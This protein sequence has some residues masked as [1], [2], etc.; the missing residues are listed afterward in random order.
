MSYA[1]FLD[2]L[3]SWWGLCSAVFFS[4]GVLRLTDESVKIMASSFFNGG[5]QLAV[6]LMQQ[7]VDFQFGAAFLF[8]SF[9]VQLVT[10]L[11]PNLQFNSPNEQY[12]IA[13]A[14]GLALAAVPIVVCIPLIARKRKAAEA[15]A[16]AYNK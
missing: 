7:K 14:V 4:V 5:E 3:A 10:K 8:L 12:W 15:I 11:L 9:F 1:L 6:E 2:L 16:R 13:L